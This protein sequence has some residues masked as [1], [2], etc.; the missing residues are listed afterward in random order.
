MGCLWGL[1]RAWDSGFRH[2]FLFCDVV[3]VVEGLQH[4]VSDLY[5]YADLF[6]EMGELLR[7]Q[8]IVELRVISL[9]D[10][11][12]A[13]F[14]ARNSFNYGLGIHVVSKAD[15]VHLLKHVVGS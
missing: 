4:G 3:S 13:D 2:V 6:A 8:W 11:V 1:R 12:A 14:L 5:E 10:N 7:H 9:E 15:A